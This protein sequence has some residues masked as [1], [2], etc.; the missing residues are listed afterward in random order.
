ML[1]IAGNVHIQP[2]IAGGYPEKA[3]GGRHMIIGGLWQPEDVKI[4]HVS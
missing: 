3:A 2:R 4:R 1:N